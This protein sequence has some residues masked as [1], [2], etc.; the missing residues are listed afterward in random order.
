MPT[1]AAKIASSCSLASWYRAIQP[2]SPPVA[3][4]VASEFA[5]A[6][7]A[8][9]APAA[10]AWV[11]DAVD[12]ILG[13]ASTVL[14]Q[15]DV[16]AVLALD[17]PDEVAVLE[18]LGEDRVAEATIEL[19]LGE[20]GQLSAVGARHGVL[21]VALGERLELRLER[22]RIALERL[23]LVVGRLGLRLGDRPRRVAGRDRAGGARVG[24]AGR[25][26]DVPDLDLVAGALVVR[27]SRR[28]SRSS[29]AA[30]SPGP[31]RRPR[32]W[33][34]GRRGRGRSGPPRDRPTSGSSR[35]RSWSSTPR[36]RPAGRC[37]RPGRSG[38][39]RPPLR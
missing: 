9:S 15:D 28:R 34:S 2:M 32:S 21:A 3:A 29:G 26:Q 19:A 16:P 33:P 20:P 25:V 27:R 24:V 23:E 18:A 5:L 1:G 11:E 14:E 17:G 7:A 35:R 6:S 10:L 30:G 13:R 39:S 22:G 4:S 38:R 31:W 12:P 36:R 37:P 8:K